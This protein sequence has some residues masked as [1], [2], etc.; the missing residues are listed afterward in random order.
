[1]RNFFLALVTFDLYHAQ[2]LALLQL[3]SMS[4]YRFFVNGS[5]PNTLVDIGASHHRFNR[6]DTVYFMAH[7]KQLGVG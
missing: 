7:G 5:N 4:L 1:M 6:E 2:S 3:L